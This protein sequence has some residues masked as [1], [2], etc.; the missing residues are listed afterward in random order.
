MRVI[1]VAVCTVQVAQIYN[2]WLRRDELN[3]DSITDPPS[4]DYPVRRILRIADTAD[5]ER[6]V[7]QRDWN[8]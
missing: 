4:E 5:R 1:P 8:P 2:G 7:D 6:E 3:G